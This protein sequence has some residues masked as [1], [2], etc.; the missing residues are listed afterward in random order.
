MPRWKPRK[1]TRTPRSAC[2]LIGGGWTPRRLGG[3]QEQHYRVPSDR[4][5]CL[6]GQA[7]SE[8]LEDVP[9]SFCA[10]AAVPKGMKGLPER[11]V[12]SVTCPERSENE[13]E[14]E[15]ESENENESEN[16]SENE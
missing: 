2:Q 10:T 16:E 3:I 9:C 1:L 5:T 7:P 12:V 8:A 15:S 14:N 4:R 11:E 13:S 6:L